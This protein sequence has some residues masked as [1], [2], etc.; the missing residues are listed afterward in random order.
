MF[1]QASRAGQFSVIGEGT[2]CRDRP[3]FSLRAMIGPNF[4]AHRRTFVTSFGKHILDVAVAQSEA[5]ME[6]DGLQ[7][8]LKHA[9]KEGGSKLDSSSSRPPPL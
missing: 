6:P 4:K 2:S 8:K 5:E 3:R 7:G 1:C 9:F